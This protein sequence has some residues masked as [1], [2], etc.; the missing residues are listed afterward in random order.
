M[1]VLLPGA[2][3]IDL[4]KILCLPPSYLQSN[5][6]HMLSAE[7]PRDSSH[8]Q[9]C[10]QRPFVPVGYS[11]QEAHHL[12]VGSTLLGRCY[13]VFHGVCW[14][15]LQMSPLL[16]FDQAPATDLSFSKDT[17]FDKERLGS[18]SLLL[19]APNC[20]F[21]LRPKEYF[22]RTSNNVFDIFL[23]DNDSAY[24]ENR[25][26]FE[27]GISE[28]WHALGGHQP[29]VKVSHLERLWKSSWWDWEF[30]PLI[31]ATKEWS[32]EIYFN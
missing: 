13:P 20:L 23:C 2:G 12:P 10:W 3:I 30:P 9:I 22:P 1:P 16:L 15:C 7:H 25:V 21:L 24:L 26:T 19:N 29:Y 6:K 32:Q 5:N 11:V 17:L 14:S 28:N 4:S 18:F 27:N 31:K 8:T